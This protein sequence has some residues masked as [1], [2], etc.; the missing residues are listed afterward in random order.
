MLFYRISDCTVCK[1]QRHAGHGKAEDRIQTEGGKRDLAPE[2]T[3]IGSWI[4]CRP[5]QGITGTDGKIC[6]LF[7]D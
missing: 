3:W 2:G 4:G 5:T 7:V 6:M 1:Y